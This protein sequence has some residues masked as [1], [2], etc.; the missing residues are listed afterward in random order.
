MNIVLDE[1]NRHPLLDRSSNN[2]GF[3]TLSTYQ[4]WVYYKENGGTLS[5]DK[6]RSTLK[7][8]FKKIMEGVMYEAKRIDLPF[9]GEIFVQ[10]TKV[11]V[12]ENKR[13]IKRNNHYIAELVLQRYNHSRIQMNLYQDV[14]LLIYKPITKLKVQKAA[15][16]AKRKNK[17][18]K[19]VK[20]F[21]KHEDYVYPDD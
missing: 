18:I 7:L 12:R 20:S 1:K 2:V 14:E 6:Y 21:K 3:N 17:D 8:I 15:I 13:M 5:L 19:F 4:N 16:K 11:P 10:E 9:F